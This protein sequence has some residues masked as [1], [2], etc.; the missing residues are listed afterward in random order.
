MYII[1][2]MNR[3][4]IL[5][6]ALSMSGCAG[7][8]S[9]DSTDSRRGLAP[10]STALISESRA[11]GA[12]AD[13]PVLIRIFKESKEL[14]LWRKARNGKYA[15]VHTYPICAYSGTLGPKVA[16]GDYQA[17]EGFYSITPG[18]MNYNSIRYLAANTGYPNQFDKAHSRTGSSVMI[19]GGCDSAGC[20]A[21]QDAP[22]QDLFAAMRDAFKGGQRSIQLQIYPYRMSTVN[23]LMHSVPK[24][25]DFWSQLKIGYDKFESMHRELNV[26]V[27]NKRYVIN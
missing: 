26:K 2:M 16:Q 8:K 17:P 5:F 1:G 15:L 11:I 12:D 3:I 18:Q 7:Y 21:I 4:L 10:Q 24:H 6:A 19:H 22:M 23:M 27:V 9:I 13:S 14:E 20:Y 25:K